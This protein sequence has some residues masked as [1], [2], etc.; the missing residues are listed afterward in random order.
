MLKKTLILIMFLGL[1]AGAYI[2]ADDLSGWIIAK[3]KDGNSAVEIGATEDSAVI[4]M[5]GKDGNHVAL[6]GLQVINGK[7]EVVLVHHAGGK[8]QT[9]ILSSIPLTTESKSNN[10]HPLGTNKNPIPM[11]WNKTPKEQGIEIG[12]W[13]TIRG[14]VHEFIA[15]GLTTKDGRTFIDYSPFHKDVMGKDKVMRL[16][17]EPKGEIK[18]NEVK[19]GVVSSNIY[20][21][22]MN[23]VVIDI[24]LLIHSQKWKS[25]YVETTFRVTDITNQHGRWNIG[26]DPGRQIENSGIRL[27]K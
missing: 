17:S 27:V 13:V 25:V 1:A 14:Y 24:N 23:P 21:P 11:V 18:S 22:H 5:L 12:D 15:A 9:T 10:D 6:I 8:K 7:S 4:V 26:T 19:L 16:Y 3:Y 2:T 20:V